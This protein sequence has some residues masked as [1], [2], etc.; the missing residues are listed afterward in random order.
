MPN[1]VLDFLSKSFRSIGRLFY[2]A[3]STDI[4][5][6]ASYFTFTGYQ[7]S[8]STKN[9][10]NIGAVTVSRVDG[11]TGALSL[12]PGGPV[13]T[14]SLGA[15]SS[16]TRGASRTITAQDAQSTIPQPNHISINTIGAEGEELVGE[17][18][19]KL[20]IQLQRARQLEYAI[21]SVK[22]RQ[23]DAKT[24][25][26]VSSYL[27]PSK[28]G[29]TLAMV[30]RLSPADL[31]LC[32][33]LTYEPRRVIKGREYLDEGRQAIHPLRQVHTP[34]RL[35]LIMSASEYAVPTWVISTPAGALGV[36]YGSISRALYF[37]DE[38][39]ARDLVDY[40]QHER[41]PYL[42]KARLNDNH[43][44]FSTPLSDYDHLTV[45]QVGGT[46]PDPHQRPKSPSCDAEGA[47]IDAWA[48]TA[49]SAIPSAV[50]VARL[51]GSPA[52]AGRRRDVRHRR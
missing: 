33:R 47:L 44:T 11:L 21:A 1:L 41:K 51:T 22:V 6:Q 27:P 32:G 5:L 25:A 36:D 2:G 8:A 23:A 20:N 19:I 28:A 26:F 38:D 31:Y 3:G 35:Y 14:A 43:Q 48:T 17:T 39:Q 34:W 15:S 45:A 40:L 13:P 50:R 24:G 16:T 18:L 10:V 29:L 46:D 4:E 37:T 12:T 30:N 49:P 7:A 52:A 42:G 9:A